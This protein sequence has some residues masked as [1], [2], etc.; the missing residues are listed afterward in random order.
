MYIYIFVV[1]SRENLLRYGVVFYLPVELSS[2]GKSRRNQ[3]HTQILHRKFKRKT[4]KRKEG[5]VENNV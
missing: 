3:E 5:Q 2:S 1:Y 4:K